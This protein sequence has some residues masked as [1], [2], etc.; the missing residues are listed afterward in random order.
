MGLPYSLVLTC[1]WLVLLDT[2]YIQG[3]VDDYAHALN[4][5]MILGATQVGGVGVHMHVHCMPR[6]IQ[7]MVCEGHV[8]HS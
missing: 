3:G 8:V 2:R 6:Y 4:S 7:W 1:L 5:T